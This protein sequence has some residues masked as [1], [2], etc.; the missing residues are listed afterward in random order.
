MKATKDDR[1]VFYFS[2]HVASVGKDKDV[3]KVIY[4]TDGDFERG[5]YLRINEVVENISAVGA[6]HALV[7]VDG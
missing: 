4:P 1:V 7:V 3:Q 5:G 6:K 2:G